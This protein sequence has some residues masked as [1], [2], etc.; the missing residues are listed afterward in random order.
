MVKAA[1]AAAA[2]WLAD[3]FHVASGTR[4]FGNVPCSSA[5]VQGALRVPAAARTRRTSAAL[6]RPAL[7]PKLV[8]TY[9]LT[10]ATHSSGLLFIGIMSSVYVRSSIGPVR[11]WST[12]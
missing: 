10:A 2:L 9:E 7:L 5:T 8:R 3:T 6:T 12:A 1:G 4:T 11:P